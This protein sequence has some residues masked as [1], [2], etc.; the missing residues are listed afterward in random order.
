MIAILGGIGAAAAWA[1]STLCSSRSSRMIAPMSVVAL[2]MLVGLLIT[3][4]LV[5]ASGVPAQLDADSG[6]WLLIS[7]AGNVAG[8]VLAYNALSDRAGGA[9][10]AARPR[11]RESIAALIALLAGESLDPGV[12]LALA[13]AA[14]GVC[15][16]AIPPSE[17]SDA[18]GTASRA[19]SGSRCSQRSCGARACT[20]PAEPRR[21]CRRRGSC[22]RRG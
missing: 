18:P 14:I 20:R 1:I 10:R 9:G 22:C 21:R 7:G 8:L 12:G 3:A 16:A 13:L 11:P 6:T 17:P 4:P 19:R 2:V 5:V 15:L